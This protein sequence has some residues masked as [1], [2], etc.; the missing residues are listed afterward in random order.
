MSDSERA[1]QS[2]ASAR[3]THVVHLIPASWPDVAA[4]VAPLV[5]RV[6]RAL[7]AVQVLVLVPT[8]D[9]ATELLREVLA[10]SA[11]ADVRVAPL[12]APRRAKRLAAAAATPQVVIGTV[13][14]VS[15]LI[16]ASALPLTSVSALLLGAA[17]ELE[18]SE[19][20]LEQ[21]LAELPKGAARLLTAATATSFVERI[22]ERHMHGARRVSAAPVDAA[23][24][25][26]ARTVEIR[27]VTATAPAAALGDVLEGVD[28]P[29]TVVVPAD[30]R[31]A[32]AV[33]AT[34]DTL[35]YGA[36]SPL[37]RVAADGATAG[38]TLVILVGA[39]SAVVLAK[40]LATPAARTV[41]LV[42]ARERASLA[43]AAPSTTLTTFSA[44][45]ALAEASAAEERQREQIRRVIR[46]GLPSREMLALE[47]LLS[48]FDPLT[49][50]GAAL[51]LY[52]RAQVVA[53]KTAEL[54]PATPAP[55]M[56]ER[57]RER[58]PRGSP[59]SRDG[60]FSRGPRK[61][62]GPPREGG[63]KRSADDRGRPPRGRD[64]PAGERGG[65]RPPF[66][67]RPKPTRGRDD[68]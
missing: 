48:E 42:T 19:A 5:A 34:L 43:A 55:A 7:A 29:I 4:R 32:L 8:G 41:A 66:K 16:K 20:T 26:A 15:A 38:A 28:A 9:D 2:S 61:F 45:T 21:V 6:D 56:G 59:P 3:S 24:A 40:V 14:T 23:V 46:E 17:D 52:E 50:A 62:D 35:G 31:R 44:S 13:D 68:R 36:E 12:A 37:V 39:P 47:P 51:V 1:E 25:S 53:R 65:S 58:S 63:F 22:M 18:S 30:A 54:R 33:R 57:P 60:G 67:P 27:N 11:A 10:L 64:G 49:L